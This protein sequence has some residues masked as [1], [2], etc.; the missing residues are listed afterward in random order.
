VLLGVSQD[1]FFMHRAYIR[2]FA[3]PCRGDSVSC[4]L[5]KNATK[6]PSFSAKLCEHFFANLR[7]NCIIL[8]DSFFLTF[9]CTVVLPCHTTK[10]M[11]TYMHLHGN[12]MF[13]CKCRKRCR[14]TVWHSTFNPCFIM[15]ILSGIAKERGSIYKYYYQKFS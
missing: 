2:C 6:K 4:T 1:F 15:Y 14:S 5:Q 13:Y 11:Y 3:L 7:K 12:R 9:F 10:R 8:E